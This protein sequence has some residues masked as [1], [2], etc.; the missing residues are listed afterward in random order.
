VPLLLRFYL[1]LL[2]FL[3]LTLGLGRRSP[4]IRARA[5]TLI[6]L[7]QLVVLA[8]WAG[9]AAWGLLVAAIA[10]LC[11]WELGA[12][13]VLARWGCSAGALAAGAAVALAHAG[14]AP[15]ALVAWVLALGTIGLPGS[16]VRHPAWGPLLAV[17]QVGPCAAILARL[18]W[19]HP[20]DGLLALILLVQFH[21]GFAYL[22]GRRFGRRRPFAARS[23]N[24]TLEG[25]AGGAAG[26]AL[27]LVVLHTLVPALPPGHAVLRGV[28]LLAATVLTAGG[29][30][31]AGSAL[32]RRRGVKDS[33]NLLPGHGGAVDRFGNLLLA[34]PVFALLAAAKVV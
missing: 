19:A 34:A 20:A 29:G 23:P 12:G 4:E 15:F 2:A 26:A 13:S 17:A 14:T 30:D 7:L 16:W 22:V 3:G 18:G 28:V 1:F 27:G 25:Y 24:K 33:G 6:L 32:K 10:A 21:D 31:L 9:P 5:G 11:G 8:L